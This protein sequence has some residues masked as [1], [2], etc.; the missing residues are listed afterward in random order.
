MS[1]IL[2]NCQTYDYYRNPLQLLP[3]LQT[4][5]VAIRQWHQYGIDFGFG[6]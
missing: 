4:K 5:A 1:A 2:F 3:G 6:V